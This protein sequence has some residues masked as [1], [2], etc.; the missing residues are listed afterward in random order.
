MAQAEISKYRGSQP[1]F[2]SL[3]REE[4]AAS[5]NQRQ[6]LDH[7]LRISAPHERWL[8]AVFGVVLTAVAAWLFLGS[9]DRAV[10]ADGF[11][12]QPGE[13]VNVSSAEP[14]HLLEY[15]VATGSQVAAGDPI[16]RQSVP[17]LER[18]IALLRDRVEHLDTQSAAGRQLLAPAR[19]V[20]L[21]LEAKRAARELLV[22]GVSG[23]VM[24]LRP[25]PGRF[26]STGTPVAQIRSGGTEGIQAVLRA[27]PA[28]ANRIRP[29]M[30]VSVEAI[31]PDGTTLQLKGE[32]AEGAVTPLPGWLA[33]IPPASAP[34]AKRIDIDIHGT[35]DISVP[36][37][38]PCRL[39]ILLGR[40]PP[41]QWHL[42]REILAFA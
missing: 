18:E 9:V 16:A 28:V 19:T 23:E 30:E 42:L 22:S 31:L 37:G 24:A 12:I 5:R 20:L 36:D 2:N 41:A 33:A 4:A 35:P 1:V 39:R 15:L 40:Q 38:T 13:R 8:L 26:L 29:G 27:A 17:E 3:F 25:E 34:D 32:V 7:L 6:Q 21:E 10:T 11:L 14:G